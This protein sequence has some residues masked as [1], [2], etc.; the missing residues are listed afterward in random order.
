GLRTEPFPNPLAETTPSTVIDLKGHSYYA[1]TTADLP[2]EFAE[3][4]RAWD[5]TLADYADAAELQD[6]I[7]A[8]DV[9]RIRAVWSRLVEEL[10]DQTFY[11]F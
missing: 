2:P 10:D 4:A 9:P 8:R 5:A 11:G 1:R 3:V 6:A 7:R